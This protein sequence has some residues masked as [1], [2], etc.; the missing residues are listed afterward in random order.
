MSEENYWKSTLAELEQG[1]KAVLVVIIDREGSAPNKPGAKM[2][3][4][5]DRVMG[6]VGGGNSEHQ[7]LDRAQILLL[8]TTNTPIKVHLDHSIDAIEES[9]GMICS[10]SQS[11]ALVPIVKDN[12]SIIK[13]I[14]KCFSDNQTGVLRLTEKG[15][16]FESGNTITKDHLYSERGSSWTYQENIGTRDRLFIVGGGHVSLALSHIMDTL[17]FHITVFD[18]RK[19][20]PT[21]NA[22]VYAHE[23]QIVSYEEIASY[24]PE[25]KNI[26]VT[27]MTFGHQSDE[28]VLEKII[29]KNC[30]YIG[31]LAS[32]S[33][34]KQ[35]FENLEGKGIAKSL[36]DKIYSPIGIKIR[37]HTPEEIA[38]SIAAEIIKVKNKE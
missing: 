22:N 28:Q 25:G 7:L 30:N 26:Y 36:L 21:M 35:V 9:S 24:I 16:D 4:M 27:I 2:F 15:L 14:I 20:L 18:D 23:K 12:N 29:A 8:E 37:S 10:G 1:R 3:V 17:G 6:T 34:K 13:K 19:E 11:F 5:E 31:M 38:I 33:K 32:A